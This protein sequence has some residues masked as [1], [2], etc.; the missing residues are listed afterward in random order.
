MLKIGTRGSQLALTQTK[1]VVRKLIE[2][3]PDLECEIVV[4]KTKGDRIQD[5]ALDKIGDKGLFVK[6]IENALLNGDIDIAIHSMKDM[7]SSVPEGLMLTVSPEREDPRDGL[8]T[9]HDIGSLVE[10]KKNAV[11][12]TGSKRRK[13]QLLDAR[14]DLEIVGIRGNVDTRIRK[15]LEGD[16]DGVVLAMAGLN[17]LDISSCE[18][19]KVLPIDEDIVIPA[20]SQGILA[21]EIRVGDGTTLAYIEKIADAKT[22]I[23]MTIERDYL[24][25]MEGSCHVPIGAYATVEGE[26]IHVC[27]LFGTE[28]GE[29]L[30]RKELDG[31]VQEHDRLG[32]ELA[33]MVKKE[34]A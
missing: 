32:S 23:Q 33:E 6:E 25:A 10:L 20:P 14:P 1:W 31:K 22:N 15:M 2:A 34:M 26:D 3:N 5:V 13:Y 8:V 19:Y 11:I 27:C 30:I 12:G 21:L 7:P 16:I 24:A 17:R 9:K 18:D 29:V 4:I 28:D